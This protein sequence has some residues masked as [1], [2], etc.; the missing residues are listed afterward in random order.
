MVNFVKSLPKLPLSALVFYFLLIG[1]WKLGHIPSPVGILRIL[2]NLYV[3]YGL[4]G[5]VFAT[6]LEGIVYLGLY[7]PGSFI[8]ALAVFLSN[9]S[10]NALLNISIL[11]TATLTLTSLINYW[12][13]R[14]VVSKDA[15]EEVL[16]VK[17]RALTRGLVLSVLHPNLLAWE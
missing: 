5:M 2:E 15:K 4:A 10:F 3:N 7:F 17:S 14:Y 1:L 8:I 9:G 12:L 6:F 13:G 11:V 16:L